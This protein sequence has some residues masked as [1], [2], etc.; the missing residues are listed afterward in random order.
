M[1]PR[2][3]NRITSDHTNIFLQQQLHVKLTTNMSRPFPSA[4][5]TRCGA[6]ISA[7]PKFV[8]AQG[9]GISVRIKTWVTLR[10]MY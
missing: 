3:Q 8:L 4:T 10:A 1:I 2:R 5:V 9:G 6:R 7:G